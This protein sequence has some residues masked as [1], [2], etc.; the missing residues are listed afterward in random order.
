[1]HG[2]RISTSAP[3]V[4]YVWSGKTGINCCRN[5]SVTLFVCKFVCVCGWV[6]S[7]YYSVY[8]ISFW[9]A[10]IMCICEHLSFIPAFISH[11][12]PEVDKGLKK[13]WFL[14]RFLKRFM[15]FGFSIQRWWDV[16]KCQDPERT[17]CT[18][19]SMALHFWLIK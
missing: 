7:V 3:E 13:T 14:E 16:K 5:I 1:M 18:P 6:F 12:K 10:C 17:S 19:F 2:L 11:T 8:T 15:L 4:W 9:E